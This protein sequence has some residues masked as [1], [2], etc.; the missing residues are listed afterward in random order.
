M[1]GLDKMLMVLGALVFQV[2]PFNPT[3]TSGESYGE[4]VGE[5]TEKFSVSAII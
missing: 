2:W 5:T 4:Y 1:W 3:E